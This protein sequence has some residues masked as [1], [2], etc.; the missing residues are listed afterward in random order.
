MHITLSTQWFW[1]WYIRIT[2]L[3]ERVLHLLERLQV[4]S[5]DIQ[6]YKSLSNDTEPCEKQGFHFQQRQSMIR[7]G[8]AVCSWSWWLQC[9]S[10]CWESEPEMR[11][12][13][14]GV[15][16]WTH[17]YSIHRQIRV[18]YLAICL[19]KKFAWLSETYMRSKS[20]EITTQQHASNTNIVLRQI[21][22]LTLVSSC[23]STK[24]CKRK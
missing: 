1:R 17:S 3:H 12:N 10:N 4:V 22:Y 24:I 18:Q 20:Q 5:S 9:C 11:E 8:N 2:E 6:E 13:E 21:N 19:R 16:L 7:L 15:C 14:G 23:V